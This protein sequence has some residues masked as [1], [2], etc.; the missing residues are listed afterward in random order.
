MQRAAARRVEEELQGLVE[1]LFGRQPAGV[2]MDEAPGKEVLP[3]RGDEPAAQDLPDARDAAGALRHVAGQEAQDLD[4]VRG[5]ALRKRGGDPAADEDPQRTLQVEGT[6]RPLVLAV[7]PL[8]LE[9][10][11][12]AGGEVAGHPFRAAVVFEVQDPVVLAEAVAVEPAVGVVEEG[13]AGVEVAEARVALGRLPEGRRVLEGEALLAERVAKAHPRA[14]LARGGSAMAL[15]DEHEV[16]PLES[17]HGDGSI[18]HLVPEL[19]DL[20]DLDRLP[21]EESPGPPC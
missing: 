6:K 19:R 9:E 14:V 12:Q 2:E 5:V 8:L 1:H 11:E 18:P 17:L 15:V 16:V 13:A 21:G 7:E 3:G 4:D 10:G 20:Q